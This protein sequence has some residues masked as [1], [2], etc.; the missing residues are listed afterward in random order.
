VFT[1]GPGYAS[2]LC[3]TRRS[4]DEGTW[5]WR[6]RVAVPGNYDLYVFGLNDAINTTEF[7]EENYN[8]S[9]DVYV[10]NYRTEV[11]DKLCERQRYGKEDAF[12]AGRVSEAHASP[13]G[14]F[15]LRLVSHDVSEDDAPGA[16]DSGVTQV[17]RQRTGYAWFNYAVLAPVPVFGRVNVNTASERVLRSLP[18]V[19]KELAAMIARGVDA[20]GRATLKPY[21]QLGDLLKVKGLTLEA[22]ARFVNLVMLESYTYTVAVE[23][24]SFSRAAAETDQLT[25]ENVAAQQSMRYIIEMQKNSDGYLGTR[26][27]EQTR[28]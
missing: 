7:L 11:Y 2:P 23:A 22:F 16:D 5:T 1:V 3:Y 13:V 24:Q 4:N 25:D 6:N 17:S 10:W 21:R 12:Y 14:D 15:R 9:I 28:L 20:N 19:D 18:G 8:G 26:L 27:L